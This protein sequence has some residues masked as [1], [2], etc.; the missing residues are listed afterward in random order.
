MPSP[1]ITAAK[2]AAFNGLHVAARPCWS[3]SV[4]VRSVLGWGCVLEVLDCVVAPIA[5]LVVDLG[6]IWRRRWPQECPCNQLMDTHLAA[7]RLGVQ[8]N[9][10]E[11]VAILFASFQHSAGFGSNPPTRADHLSRNGS[12]RLWVKHLLP[13]LAFYDVLL[14]RGWPTLVPFDY[15][16]LN[17]ASLNGTYAD[18]QPL[19][20]LSHGIVSRPA[21]ASDSPA[22]YW[23][24]K[25]RPRGPSWKPLVGMTY[26]LLVRG[27]FQIVQPVVGLITIQMVALQVAVCRKG[28]EC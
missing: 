5:I 24:G 14:G 27:P 16:P 17:G 23:P 19:S 21:A 22:P 3:E 11:E 4:A 10:R 7:A 9:R 28:P 20:C 15:P 18:P 12:A 8:P 1:L 2:R 26:V 25:F 13:L 6:V